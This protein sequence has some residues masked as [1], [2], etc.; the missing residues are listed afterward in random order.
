MAG[1]LSTIRCRPNLGKLECQEDEG[2]CTTKPFTSCALQL[3]HIFLLLRHQPTISPTRIFTNSGTA[4]EPHIT[5]STRCEEC[6]EKHEDCSGEMPAYAGCLQKG[7]TCVYSDGNQQ[8]ENM[9]ATAATS[10]VSAA[11]SE[12]RPSVTTDTSPT[13]PS[14]A[15]RSPEH[16]LSTYTPVVPPIPPPDTLSTSLSIVTLTLKPKTNVANETQTSVGSLIEQK[17]DNNASSFSW[18][19]QLASASSLYLRIHNSLL[20]ILP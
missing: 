1:F 15:Q 3:Q 17:L 2:P 16:D 4:M 11:L 10:H 18:Y 12:V 19:V 7:K 6:S 8:I 5:A 20:G 13:G 14:D 9:N